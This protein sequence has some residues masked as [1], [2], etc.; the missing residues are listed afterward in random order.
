M[1]YGRDWKIAPVYT[2]DKWQ[3]PERWRKT[4]NLIKSLSDVKLSEAFFARMPPHSQIA[5]HSDNLN[6]ILTSHLALELE[7]GLCSIRVGN[8]EKQWKEGETMVFDTT[9]I[10]SCRNDS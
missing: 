10:H 6:Y 1:G 4:Q 9:Y 5:E 2:A 8:Q 3:Y 7:E